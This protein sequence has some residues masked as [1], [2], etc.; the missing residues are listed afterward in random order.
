MSTQH[1]PQP[2]IVFEAFDFN[3]ASGEL[4][5]HGRVVR[6]QGQ[7][8]QILEALLDEPGQLVTREALQ[9][10]LWSG[11]VSGDFEHGLN[12][13]VNKLRQTLGDWAEE[14]R[15]IETVAG[16]GYRFI[17]STIQQARPVLEMQAPAQPAVPARFRVASWVWAALAGVFLIVGATGYWI[18]SSRHEAPSAGRLTRFTI[19]PPPGYFLEGGGNRQSL[20]VSQD[21]SQVAFTAMDGSS[22]FRIFIRAIGELESRVVP[23]SDG[24]GTLFWL[25]DGSL[26]FVAGG[27]VRRLGSGAQASQILSET[28]PNAS[29]GILLS[30][31]RVLMAN[32]FRSA[33]LPANGGPIEHLETNYPWPQV[34]P[35]G[36]HIL[37]ALFDLKAMGWRIR[38]SRFKDS[39]PPREILVAGSRAIYSGSTRSNHGYLLYARG[40][41]LLAQPFDAN[42]SQTTGDA[43]VIV[44]QVYSFLPVGS[45]DFSI[46]ARGELLVYQS[47]VHRSQLIWV[48]RKGGHLRGAGPERI[49]A[50]D[51]R[52][53][54]DG[55]RFASALFDIERGVT[56]IWVTDVATGQSRRQIVG[57]GLVNAPVWSP[58]SKWMAFMRA[59]E[60]TPKLFIRT[61][62]GQETERSLPGDGY[63]VPTDWTRDGRFILYTNTGP[64]LVA[65]EGQGDI[66]VADLAQG[67]QLTPLIK[68]QFHES[69]ASASPD[70]K[71]VA[72]LSTKSGRP[73]IYLQRL[74][75]RAT[76]NVA[77]PQY[78][79]SR[80]GAI[81][82]RWRRDGKE[83]FYLG[84][85][86]RIHAVAIGLEGPTPAIGAP[87][88][89][90]RIEAGAITA[91]HSLTGF[92]VADDGRSFVVPSVSPSIE[93]S[94]LVAVQNWEELLKPRV[95]PVSSSRR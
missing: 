40:G 46:S 14:P 27:K 10:R 29:S 69:S 42:A 88:P 52:L 8:I 65:N 5:K 36:E 71:W 81:C 41:A 73:E 51:A 26:T 1:T 74:E 89:L 13:A 61:L 58:D 31:G 16:K 62:E 45:A 91:V 44:S 63:Q 20:A 85:D 79:V 66:W 3:P 7:P 50:K 32:R 86:G 55:T 64:T 82:L 76:L 84:G 22:R 6:L 43:R 54:P 47:V 17:A 67:G 95:T 48:D 21:G 56:D 94:T 11:A 78:L 34:L 70:G 35:D 25:P 23:D 53:S 12:A 90:F 49:S 75:V 57:P 93:G 24:A 2:K 37:Q 72:F 30:R 4:R 87:Q 92:D 68:T 59:S 60:S 80:Q 33:I 9:R 28:T 38:T 39:A 15:F 77:G 18:G 19:A 83:L